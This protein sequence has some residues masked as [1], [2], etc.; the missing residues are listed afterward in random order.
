MSG[1][2]IIPIILHFLNNFAAVM[3]YFIFGDAE[4]ISSKVQ[5]PVE[6]GSSFMLLLFMVVLF[7]GVLF[8]IKKYYSK[9]IKI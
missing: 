8:T 1:S 6:L 2:I 4:L 9:A 7:A 3:L 5:K